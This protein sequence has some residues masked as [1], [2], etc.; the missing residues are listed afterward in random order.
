MSTGKDSSV[1]YAADF[2][3][4]SIVIES[5]RPVKAGSAKTISGRA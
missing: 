4:R 1:V 2:V 5:L 3:R